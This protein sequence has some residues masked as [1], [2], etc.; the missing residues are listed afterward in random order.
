MLTRQLDADALG[1]PSPEPRKSVLFAALSDASGIPAWL[2]IA[3]VFLFASHI[4][5]VV[6]GLMKGGNFL[7]VAAFCAIMIGAFALMAVHRA[8]A[9]EPD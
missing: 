8:M 1:V 7:W 3:V 5:G 6:V 4:V 2:R 9:A